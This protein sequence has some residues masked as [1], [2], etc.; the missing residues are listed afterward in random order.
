[1]SFGGVVPNVLAGLDDG[2]RGAGVGGEDVGEEE[3]ASFAAHD[4]LVVR[5]GEEPELPFSADTRGVVA[6]PSVER[7]HLPPHPVATNTDC[8]SVSSMLSI[9]N[10]HLGQA[11]SLLSEVVHLLTLLRPHA[12]GNENRQTTREHC[13]WFP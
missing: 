8:H 3:T 9:L 11:A 5:L 13:I 10:V 4:D 6:A 7:E 12:V 1:M 2:Y